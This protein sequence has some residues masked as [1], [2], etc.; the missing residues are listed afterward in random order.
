MNIAML[1]TYRL[2]V[3][4]FSIGRNDILS[5]DSLWPDMMR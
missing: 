1:L 5:D 2:Q 4:C 3:F